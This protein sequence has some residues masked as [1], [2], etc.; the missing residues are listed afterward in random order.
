MDIGLER[1]GFQ[2]LAATD[3]DAIVARTHAQ[4][5]QNVPFIS[6]RIGLLT[7][8][9]LREA[10]GLGRNESP[11]LLAGG[12]PCPPFSKSR[13]YRKDKP[14]S[15]RDPVAAETI[16]GYLRLLK[17][18]RPRAFVLENVKG[19]AYGVHQ[20][21]LR[22]IRT[23]AERLGYK[24]SVEVLNA[25]NYG[26]PQ[27][28][29]RCI[30]IGSREGEIEFPAPTHSK[31]PEDGLLPWVGCGKVLKDL[32][33]RA[34][35]SDEGHFAGGQHH[36]LLQQIP[37]GDN[38]LFFT[39]KRGH[40]RPKFEWRSRYWSFL[41]KLSPELPSW[42][43]Q[44]RRSNNMGPFHWRNRI[45]RIGEIKR[46]QTFSDDFYLAGTIEQQWRQI[47]NAVP[48][49]LAEILGQGIGEHLEREGRLKRAA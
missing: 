10:A 11:D 6:K 20:D 45:L 41:L 37:P 43:I 30:V 5:F 1:A 4:N 3:F 46:L 38:Y 2:M 34:N 27:I 8:S 9:E 31:N 24:V 16:G 49:R 22:S 13:F 32:D 36:G 12:P 18:L 29:E 21:A 47:G 44:A 33:T 19:L 28:R 23:T 14:R 15:L 42:T 26:V 7:S 48:P 17:D 39:K 35:A 40:S 25:A